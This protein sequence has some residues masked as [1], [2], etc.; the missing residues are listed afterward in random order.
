MILK[1]TISVFPFYRLEVSIIL[2]NTNT[3]SI[4]FVILQCKDNLK[5]TE[6]ER[7]L[8]IDLYR[9]YGDIEARNKVIESVYR[10][11]WKFAIKYSKPDNSIEP[12]DLFQLG[13]LSAI[14]AIDTFEPDKSKFLT[15]FSRIYLNDIRMLYR[16]LIH[17]DDIL[18]LDS[19]IFEGKDGSEIT[20]GDTICDDAANEEL[21]QIEDADE[22]REF[23]EI[24]EDIY[25][26]DLNDSQRNC[27]DQ[28]FGLHGK[29]CYKTHEEYA[30]EVNA[31]RAN[32]SRIYNTSIRKIANGFHNRQLTHFNGSNVVTALKNIKARS[33]P[34]IIGLDE[35]FPKL[36][37]TDS[38]IVRALYGYKGSTPQRIRVLEYLLGY[39][40]YTIFNRLNYIASD[41][42]TGSDG[43]DRCTSRLD[44]VLE[45]ID[46]LKPKE[47]KIIK[48]IYGID[49]EQVYSVEDFKTGKPIEGI[50]KHPKIINISY[51]FARMGLKRKYYDHD[52]V[53]KEILDRYFGMNGYKPHTINDICVSMNLN[54]TIVKSFLKQS[55]D[56][57]DKIIPEVIK[58]NAETQ[59]FKEI[60]PHVDIL[61]QLIIDKMLKEDEDHRFP[62]MWISAKFGISD[63]IVRMK[64]RELLKWAKEPELYRQYMEDFNYYKSF[65][66]KIYDNCSDIM[67]EC[68]DKLFGLHDHPLE[69][70][71][72]VYYWAKSKFEKPSRSIFSII[73]S[74]MSKIEY[75]LSNS[76]NESLKNLI[77]NDSTDPD[78]MSSI[79]RNMYFGLN[80]SKYH[81]ILEIGAALDITSNRIGSAITYIYQVIDNN[82]CIPTKPKFRKAKS[83][84]K[85]DGKSS[86]T[87]N[88]KAEEIQKVL[89]VYDA[90]PNKWKITVDL[91]YGL[92]G[93][94]PTTISNISTS[95]GIS[96]SGIANILRK[97]RNNNIPDQNTYHYSDKEALKLKAIEM[98]NSLSPTWKKLAD[99]Y[100]G[101]HG[102]TV[103]AKNHEITER[104]GIS[105]G[106]LYNF[107]N[108]LK[109]N[110]GKTPPH[111]RTR[112]GMKSKE[113][114]DKTS[115]TK[116]GKLLEKDI[117]ENRY[118]ALDISD[119]VVIDCLYGMHGRKKMTLEEMCKTF[120]LGPRKMKKRIQAIF[121]FILHDYSM[122][123]N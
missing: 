2:Y 27:I 113:D 58:D 102:E 109:N 94:E 111:G 4:E 49:T 99:V 88:R 44:E 23:L 70:D 51:F 14:K 8:L 114:T 38:Y 28:R 22:L 41:E 30:K 26:N 85:N 72:L 66:E 52:S 16:K 75:L 116:E 74:Q 81:T 59:F 56:M 123:S 108:Y 20:V 76:D 10:F 121:D 91:Y 90:L 24:F 57:N 92:H 103:V 54:S 18:S 55:T 32:I 63:Q 120:N 122:N 45:N 42:F 117:I 34:T 106:S 31:S 46:L 100:F 12:D 80:G 6:V 15:Y 96:K 110:D 29:K 64:R 78:N 36:D 93:K 3:S 19:I 73:T 112:K 82:K 118:V 25:K 50:D 35:K 79:I 40:K 67:K 39:T 69:N 48:A 65:A 83:N 119:Q 61:L 107:I 1:A 53:E 13:I 98:Y 43:L 104:T 101:L 60:Y 37:A 89:K 5:I 95:L 11:I 7:N 77:A 9:S 71:I 21:L 62:T 68:L 84:K 105:I 33:I 86:Y 17:N 115:T 47:Q 87:L 97:V